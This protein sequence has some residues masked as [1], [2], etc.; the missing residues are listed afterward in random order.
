[1]KAQNALNWAVVFDASFIAAGIFIG[2]L[3]VAIFTGQLASLWWRQNAWR[4][5]WRNKDGDREDD[6]G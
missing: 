5:R 3:I 4:R 6:D 1:V 2:V